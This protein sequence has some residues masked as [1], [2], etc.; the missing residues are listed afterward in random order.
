MKNL[1]LAGLLLSCIIVSCSTGQSSQERISLTGTWVG[2]FGP[3]SYDRN[4]ITLE[5]NW[6]GKSLTGMVRPGVPGAKM[7]RNFTS[8]PIQNGS[9]DP[10]TGVITFEAMFRPRERH[11]FIEGRLKKNVL[12]G[13]W[14]RPDE[15]KDGDFK[16]MKKP[17]G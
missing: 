1:G 2:D 13:A 10:A 11:Y 16:L 8:F 6:D 14:N 17:A 9:F 5:L 7:Y 12:S 4:T 15:N 3:A